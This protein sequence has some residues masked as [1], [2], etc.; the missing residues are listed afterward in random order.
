PDR[1][2]LA[3]ARRG[4]AGAGR[5]GVVRVAARRGCAALSPEP[6][7]LRHDRVHRLG[8]VR[9]SRALERDPDGAIAADAESDANLDARQPGTAQAL[10]AG[11]RGSAAPD[12][13]RASRSE[14]ILRD[15]GDL[16]DDVP[17]ADL[18]ATPRA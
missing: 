13:R 4:G 11:D 1:E 15:D 18:A 3:R 9:R 12:G 6:V 17:A 8:A 5:A 10:R 14:T 7:R 16:P 2:T